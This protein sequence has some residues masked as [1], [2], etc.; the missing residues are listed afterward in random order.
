[1]YCFNKSVM[2]VISTMDILFISCSLTAV[3]TL[4]TM[5]ELVFA[6]T[7]CAVIFAFL[8]LSVTVHFLII[9][10]VLLYA[11]NLI[12]IFAISGAGFVFVY[13]YGYFV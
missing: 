12:C 6:I 9:G 13:F 1:M 8:F 10:I 2:V 3:S 7:S 5:F 11:L 4:I